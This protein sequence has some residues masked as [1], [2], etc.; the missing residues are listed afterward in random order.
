MWIK[1]AAGRLAILLAM[2]A[3][4][5]FAEI[6]KSC[7]FDHRVPRGF[8]VPLLSAGNPACAQQIVSGLHELKGVHESIL[9]YGIHQIRAVCA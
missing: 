5:Q 8:C 3:R 1:D 7:M 4:D 6:W 2:D 9:P